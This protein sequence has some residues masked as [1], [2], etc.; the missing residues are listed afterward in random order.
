M[1]G[2]T[3]AQDVHRCDLWEE[4]IVDMLCVLCPRK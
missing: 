2:R 3:D 4:N 1:D